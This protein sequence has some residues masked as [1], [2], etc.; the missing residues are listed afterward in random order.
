M[1]KPNYIYVASSWRNPI[2][3]LVI[4][5]LREAGLNCYDFKNP[6]EG[7]VGFS[8]RE[9]NPARQA[10][11]EMA[12][13]GADPRGL[14]L[15]TADDYLKMIVHPRAEEGFN[16][17]FDAMKRADAC[18]LVLP[19]GRS[20]HL[21]A[22]WFMGQNKECIVLLDNPVIPELMYKMGTGFARNMSEVLELWT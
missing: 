4:G 20:A 18:L 3:P 6:A 2:Q 5:T 13:P 16:S 21:E 11:F 9:T 1:S 15:E 19:C 8:W 14:D 12:E 7:S 10:R 17:D 22:G